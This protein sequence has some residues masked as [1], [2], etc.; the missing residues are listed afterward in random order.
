MY[1]KSYNLKGKRVFIKG[2]GRGI[3]LCSADALAEARANI[4]ISDI[5]EK[6][7]EEGMPFCVLKTIK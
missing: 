4:V 5:D 7:L 1:K 3:G 6:L 2:G